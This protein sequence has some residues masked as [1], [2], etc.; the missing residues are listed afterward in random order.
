[1]YNSIP[2][3]YIDRT[4]QFNTTHFPHTLLLSSLKH[5]DHVTLCVCVPNDASQL[6]GVVCGCGAT[7]T[8]NDNIIILIIRCALCAW[9]STVDVPCITN[10]ACGA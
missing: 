4:I 3:P 1:M 6:G 9:L 10:K 7:V 2:N 5:V 8:C